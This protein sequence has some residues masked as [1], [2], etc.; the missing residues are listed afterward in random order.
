MIRKA[1]NSVDRCRNI[2]RFQE[3]SAASWGELAVA[4]HQGIPAK[5]VEDLAALLG[6]PFDELCRALGLPL[7]TI[8]RKAKNQE[9]LPAVQGERVLGLQRIVGQ[10]QTMVEECGNPTNF[11][12]GVWIGNWLLSPQPA[13]GGGSGMDF[14]G[15]VTGEQ[16]LS[17]LLMRN[18]S[19]AY[20]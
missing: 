18:V 20:S 3:A 15:T 14:L 5:E 17:D 16:L 4:V 12:V 13:L 11:D 10:V 1:K 8:R 9:L 6:L 2:Q 19:G 7:S